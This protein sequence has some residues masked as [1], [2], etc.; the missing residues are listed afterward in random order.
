MAAGLDVFVQRSSGTR[1]VPNSFAGLAARG[2]VP[3]WVRQSQAEH[4]AALPKD[5]R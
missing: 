3:A 5:S 4:P 1:S 2:G